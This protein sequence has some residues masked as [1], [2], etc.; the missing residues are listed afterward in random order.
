MAIYVLDERNLFPPVENAEPDG[1]LA[2]GGDLSTERLLLAYKNGI[3]PWYSDET[4][5]LWYSPP[6]RFVLYPNELKISKSM[7]Q[8]LRSG[9]FTITV[10]QCFEKVIDACSSVPR[11]G[12]DG[13]WI[14]DEMKD[15]YI[16]LHKK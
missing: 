9:K 12:Q 7:K 5:I 10:D 3:F 8:V 16:Q 6:E 1:L 14:T 15:A 11:E 2:V 4:P 13:T